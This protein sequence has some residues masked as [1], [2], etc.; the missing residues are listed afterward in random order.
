MKMGVNKRMLSCA[1]VQLLNKV[2][3]WGVHF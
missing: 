3:S 2:E 1:T